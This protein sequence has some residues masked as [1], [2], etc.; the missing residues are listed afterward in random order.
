MVLKHYVWAMLMLAADSQASDLPV[1]GPLSPGPGGT[2]EA[3]RVS[4]AAGRQPNATKSVT[5]PR[6]YNNTSEAWT[7]RINITD[8]AV[9][10][11]ISDLGLPSAD[12]SQG[13]RVANTQWQL[14]WPGSSDSFQEFLRERNAS[15][16]F[17]GIITNKPSNITDHLKDSDN[18]NCTNVLGD[19]CTRSLT[20]AV[21]KDG[22][23]SY[24]TLPG[25]DSSL[26]ASSD[27]PGIGVGT[28]KITSLCFCLCFC[29]DI[30]ANNLSF[31]EGISPN[32]NGT[33][34]LGSNGTLFYRTT[35]TYTDGNL[36]LFN[37]SKSALQ[38][39]LMD[40]R[41]PPG[42]SRGQ[43]SGPIVLCQIVDKGA[44]PDKRGSAPGLRQSVLPLYAITML[45]T[46]F[47]LI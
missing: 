37:A 25:C 33:G 12:F 23:I 40:F 15:A 29:L 16:R 21:T 22:P 14:Q 41:Y 46:L 20:Q 11:R 32:G 4:E 6:I 3:W 34:V 5:F 39:L 30:L 8:M 44:A 9:P 18:G 24:A 47:F 38:V 45:S 31:A 17:M 10:N 13:L 1:T 27:N 19:E 42:S 2:P 7:W 26:G 35:S 28:S 43:T 36:N